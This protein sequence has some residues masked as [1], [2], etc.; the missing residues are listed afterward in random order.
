LNEVFLKNYS[1]HELP[2]VV[3]SIFTASLHFGFPGL[4]ATL[5]C[6][7]GSQLEKL[8]AALLDIRH[9][10]RTSVHDCEEETDEREAAGRKNDPSES[11]RRMQ[12][13]LNNC[14]RHHQE[15]KR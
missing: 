15:I 11:F 2:Q 12:Q 5:A 9:T 1:I 6:I 7:A 13:Q 10:H 14:I 3:A 8:R 4:Y